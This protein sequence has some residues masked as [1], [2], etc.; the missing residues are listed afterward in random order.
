M[1]MFMCFVP[2]E[3]RGKGSV[4]ATIRGGRAATYTDSKTRDWMSFAEDKAREARC[5]SAPLSGPL[6]VHLTAI[7]HRPA[8][9]VPKGPRQKDPPPLNR[10]YVETKPDTDNISKGALDAI[11]KAGVIHDDAQVA[12]EVIEKFYA[13]ID[14]HGVQEDEGLYISVNEMDCWRKPSAEKKTP[15]AS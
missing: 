10:I 5:G 4:R 11:K 6:R 14:E 12:H 3:P 15:R 2:G 7:V 9:A 13:A 1:R 8:E